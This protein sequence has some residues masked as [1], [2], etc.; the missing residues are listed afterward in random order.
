MIDIGVNLTSKRFQKD[1][2]DVIARAKNA[3]I[4]N[5][6]ITGT[7]IEESEHALKLAQSDT[8]FL[9]C[10]AGI[11]PHDASTFNESSLDKLRSLAS[12][13]QVKAIGE[14]GLDFNRNF[15]TPK[16]QEI[17]VV[18]QIELAIELQLPLLCM[19]AMQVNALSHYSRLIARN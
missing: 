5:L 13:P 9:Y 14:C 8:D 7:N 18:A 2:P 11:H 17:A 4:Q 12:N 3:E 1:L 19:N 15:S 10:T 16:E 6:I